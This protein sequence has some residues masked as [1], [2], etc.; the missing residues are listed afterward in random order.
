ME[1][2]IVVAILGILLTLLIPAL[3][4]IRE[5]VERIVCMGNLRSIHTALSSYLTDNQSWPQCTRGASRTV[6]EKFWMT[7]LQE[8]GLKTETW[9]CPTLKRSLAS[10]VLNGDDV[11]NMHYIPA[12]FDEN[13]MTPYKWPAMPWAVE[14]GD[15]HHCGNLIIRG[16]GAI[17]NM[18][19]IF[20]EAGVG[21]QSGDFTVHQLK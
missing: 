10:A 3:K 18:T 16:D 11:P 6:S 21:T 5:R 1:V 9:S 20:S 17:K 4:P 12:Q 19:D 15:M 13:P 14:M 7:T 8:Y 2:V